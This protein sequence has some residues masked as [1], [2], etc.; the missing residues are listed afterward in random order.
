MAAT[1][2]APDGSTSELSACLLVAAAQADLAITKD[3]GGDI[4]S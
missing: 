3:D 2:T 1:A 4:G